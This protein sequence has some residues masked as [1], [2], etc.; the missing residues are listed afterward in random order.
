MKTKQC[1][2]LGCAHSCFLC[3]Y[4]IVQTTIAGEIASVALVPFLVIQA[5]N[6]FWAAPWKQREWMF[7]MNFTCNVCIIWM[8]YKQKQEKTELKWVW[9]E[10]SNI[11]QFHNRDSI[12]LGILKTNWQQQW[13][14]MQCLAYFHNIFEI[15][16]DTPILCQNYMFLPCAP[17]AFKGE[18]R[19]N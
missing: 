7:L 13:H 9:W 5:L 4:I 3:L 6:I 1:R 16:I 11:C 18:L 19:L 14:V 15:Q 17:R 2:P 12:I 10:N 8:I